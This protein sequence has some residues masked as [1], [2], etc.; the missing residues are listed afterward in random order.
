MPDAPVNTEANEPFEYWE[1]AYEAIQIFRRYLSDQW[2]YSF[3]GP[4]ALNVNAALAIIEKIHRKP[5]RQLRLLEEVKAF[6]NGVL[7]HFYESQKKS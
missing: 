7:T 5:A 2:T 6:A 3:G 4:A 1:D